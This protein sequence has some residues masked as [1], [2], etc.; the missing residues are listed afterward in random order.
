MVANLKITQEH[1]DKLESAIRAV[2]SEHPT[3]RE[4]YRT[5]GLSDVRFM[6]DALRASQ[7]DG[8]SGITWICDNLYS[9]LNDSHITSALRRIIR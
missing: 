5:N 7:I 8:V 3:A 9:Y 2:M 6:W 1:Y 4:S